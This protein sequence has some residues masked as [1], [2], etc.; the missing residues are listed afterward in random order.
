[1][2]KFEIRGFRSLMTCAS[3]AALIAAVPGL[4]FAQSTDVGGP[5]K[6]L[7]TGTI[8]TTNGNVTDGGANG[9]VN[10]SGVSPTIT[11]AG[12]T[13]HS[14]TANSPGINIFS[15]NGPA[16]GTVST[17]LTGTNN[18]SATSNA[19]TVSGVAEN[20]LLNTLGG[21]GTYAGGLNA[22]SQGGTATI[23]NGANTITGSSSQT[24]LQANAGGAKAVIVDS[25]GGTI[26][27]G[28]GINGSSQGG[29]VTIGEGAGVT[30]VVT[31]NGANTNVDVAGTTNGAGAINIR[32]GAGGTIDGGGTGIYA[33]NANGSGSITVNAGAAIGGTT[34]VGS[35]AIDARSGSGSVNITAT[36][37]LASTS[38]GIYSY[39][40]GGAG[41]LTIS[42]VGVNS[43]GGAGVNGNI[44]TATPS[45][46][47]LSYTL[48]GA[49]QVQGTE[50]VYLNNGGSGSVSVTAANAGSSF[51]GT[52]GFAGIEV[53]AA[54]GAIA[55]NVAGTVSGSSS[56]VYAN[57]VGAANINGGGAVNVG[58]AN[59]RIGTVS[60]T[61]ANGI[62]AAGAG[63]VTVY[64]TQ[65]TGGTR[66]ILASSQSSGTANGA[67]LSRCHWPSSRR[68][69]RRARSQ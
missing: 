15:N 32:T 13:V 58:T 22:N 31:S 12:A 51:V 28:F 27:S 17:I 9:P 24:G 37:A 47:A 61:T 45:S 1:M 62:F 18:V 30:T 52:N 35:T 65:A 6:A 8:T 38:N 33:N 16:G 23:L 39:V 66:G 64:A 10:V 43:T 68:H 3:T 59:Q 48:T 11:I 49:N 14:T 40:N 36:A 57:S 21:G 44:F 63:D 60:G 41:N 19:I 4:A 2:S 56:G 46:G 34:R 67:V 53:R 29:D 50:A 69:L 54:G 55:V 25:T 7:T 42:S 26:V 5:G 20:A